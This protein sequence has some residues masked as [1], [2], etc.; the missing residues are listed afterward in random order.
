MWSRSIF[1]RVNKLLRIHRTACP[2]RFEYRVTSCPLQLP[3]WRWHGTSN[4]FAARAHRKSPSPTLYQ[5]PTL[6]TFH[7]D[8]LCPGLRAFILDPFR[9]TKRQPR[10]LSPRREYFGD[11]W[12]SPKFD[13]ISDQQLP[14]SRS[15]CGLRLRIHQH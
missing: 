10:H 11:T 1:S 13:S 8:G 9:A 12:I 3:R 4:A 15:L 2:R 7:I 6:S 14:A 5:V